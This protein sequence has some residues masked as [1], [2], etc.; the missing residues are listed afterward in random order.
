[1]ADNKANNVES[2]IT[3]ADVD[4]TATLEGLQDTHAQ[5]SSEACIAAG[6]GG[7]ADHTQ[8]AIEAV[9]ALSRLCDEYKRQAAEAVKLAADADRRAAMPRP[10]GILDAPSFVPVE[11]GTIKAT[12]AGFNDR[13]A[14][15]TGRLSELWAIVHADDVEL[16]DDVPAPMPTPTP[17]PT[18]GKAKRK[19]KPT[20]DARVT[21]ILAKVDSAEATIDGARQVCR[22]FVDGNG[23][24]CTLK[25]GASEALAAMTA[26][27]RRHAVA[28]LEV[29]T[30][31]TGAHPFAKALFA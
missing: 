16:L 22:A 2:T 6:W 25:D 29:N 13:M 5:L 7:F 9:N 26:V 10:M 8:A 4:V 30:Y 24:A 17:T 20:M 11:A 1:M 19:A 21:A 18:K 31:R 27:Q 28:C 15:L 14:T 23:D 3:L 12:V